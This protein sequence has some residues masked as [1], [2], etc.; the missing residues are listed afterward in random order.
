MPTLLKVLGNG[1]LALG[2]PLVRLPY[3]KEPDKPFSEDRAN[4]RRDWRNVTRDL[5]RS[6]KIVKERHVSEAHRR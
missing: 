1:F 6:V 3:Q 5:A 2:T 4:L